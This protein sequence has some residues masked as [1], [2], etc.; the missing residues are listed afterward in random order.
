MHTI[1]NNLGR[2]S[3]H[4]SFIEKISR[5]FNEL[6]LHFDWAKIQNYGKDFN[7]IDI[8]VGEC[9]LV[10]FGV[11]SE[12]FLKHQDTL[13][14]GQV[15]GSDQV[16]IPMDIETAFSLI[17]HDE[18]SNN[19]FGQTLSLSGMYEGVEGVYW[20]EYRIQFQSGGF[21]WNNHV[22]LADWHKGSIP[23]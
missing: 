18:F 1:T 19:P 9:Y 12:V 15:V 17:G 3:F 7:L 21:Y 2:I 16:H 11:T 22:T 23:Q 10:L 14:S 8:V 4:D 20:L 13:G 6:I 5:S